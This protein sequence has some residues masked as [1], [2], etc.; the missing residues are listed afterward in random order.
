MTTKKTPAKSPSCATSRIRF[1]EDEVHAE[2]REATM[3]TVSFQLPAEDACMLAAIAKSF[4]RSTAAFGG[5]RLAEHVTLRF[6]ALPPEDRRACSA[7]ADAEQTCH[8]ESKGIR[9]TTG[10]NGEPGCHH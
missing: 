10:T 6:L 2:F 9:K 4:G 7:E 5:E 1:F 3:R 8:E